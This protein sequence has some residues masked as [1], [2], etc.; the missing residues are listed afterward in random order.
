MASLTLKNL[1]D[2][3][4]DLLRDRADK[5]RR[6]LNQQ[7][8]YL[9]ER[10]LLEADPMIEAQRQTD[11]WTQLAGLWESDLTPQEEID[12]IYASRSAGRDIEL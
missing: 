1:P 11:E 4:L 6:S 8:I 7:A 9:L 2:H 10:A 3:L 5:D 12:M